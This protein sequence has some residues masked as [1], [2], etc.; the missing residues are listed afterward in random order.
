MKDVIARIKALRLRPMSRIL[1]RPDNAETMA[2]DRYNQ[3]L[4][5]VINA[6]EPQPRPNKVGWWLFESEDGYAVYYVSKEWIELDWDTGKYYLLE[7][8]DGKC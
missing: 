1:G 2:I 4:D 5:N 6:L 7:V 3:A 8:D